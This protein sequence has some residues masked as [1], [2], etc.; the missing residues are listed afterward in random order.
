MASSVSKSQETSQGLP[1]F[2]QQVVCRIDLLDVP[3]A[4]DVED[5]VD[6][7]D[8]DTAADEA[9]DHLAAVALADAFHDAVHGLVE[10]FLRKGLDQVMG[11]PDGKGFDGKFFAR[12][13]EDDFRPALLL[14][15]L[16]GN[17]RPQQAGHTDIQQ[18]DVEIPF[19]FKS[20][21]E[22]HGIVIGKDFG[23][24]LFIVEIL[25][26]CLLND[27]QLFL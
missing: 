3:I 27:V 12:R 20:I 1:R 24:F 18:D 17:V 6:F 14:V 25:L 21:D 10:L 7:F 13:Q 16:C 5:G 4:F 9:E 23:R 22:I 26:D 19:L 2:Q 8:P 15:H 11:S